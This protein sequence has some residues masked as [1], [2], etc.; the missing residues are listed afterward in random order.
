M[1][2]NLEKYI[3]LKLFLQD[4][5]DPYKITYLKEKAFAIA[6]RVGFDVNE[7]FVY[8][9]NLSIRPS[10]KR[11]FASD[12]KIS[13]RLKELEIRFNVNPKQAE[14]DQI[15]FYNAQAGLKIKK[16][17][18]GLLEH[19][20][21]TTLIRIYSGELLEKYYSFNTELI[22]Y[23]SKNLRRLDHKKIKIVAQAYP[24][25]EFYQR[26]R[27]NTEFHETDIDLH[28]NKDVSLHLKHLSADEKLEIER[29]LRSQTT[30]NQEGN[31][32]DPITVLSAI[33]SCLKIIDKFVGITEKLSKKPEK[34]HSVNAQQIDDKL[35]ILQNGLIAEEIYA[36]QLRLNH[37]DEIR[38]HTLK[39]KVDF[40]WK[41]FNA[42][43]EQLPIS[44]VDERAR[45]EVK[46]D[47]LKK[48][49]CRDFREM[50]KIFEAT[51]GIRLSDHYTLYSVCESVS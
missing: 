17:V 8:I 39:R 50:I 20:G 31:G 34:S 13:E 45:L 38:F 2:T 43:D 51:L 40:T 26:I 14:K 7:F 46:M 18:E 23:V 35:E 30:D 16:G 21:E 32:M 19:F 33:T 42:I 4:E 5:L 41:Q 6:S 37:W 27:R 1:T 22:I 29:W 3:G 47:E 28:L 44:S 12:T 25:D 11:Y 36:N 48:E 10:S 49:L 15:K 24:T 9:H